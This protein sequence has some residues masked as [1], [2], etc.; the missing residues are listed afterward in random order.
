MLQLICYSFYSIFLSVMH[1]L[2]P[3]HV[4]FKLNPRTYKGGRGGCQ[5]LFWC[6]FLSF[7]LN[8]KM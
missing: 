1:I 7:F 6:F 4:L 8:D 3:A 2:K 5:P